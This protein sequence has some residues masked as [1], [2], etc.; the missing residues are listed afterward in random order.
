MKAMLTAVVLLVS[1][2]GCGEQDAE[3]QGRRAYHAGANAEGNPHRYSDT[4]RVAW[5][6]GWIAAAEENQAKRE[7]K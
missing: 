2:C 4:L 5:L 3:R 6:S 1:L 7:E